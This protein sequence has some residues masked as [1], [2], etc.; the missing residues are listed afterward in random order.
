MAAHDRVAAARSP[1]LLANVM[2][3]LS[4]VAGITLYGVTDR[5]PF[6]QVLSYEVLRHYLGVNAFSKFNFK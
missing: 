4:A 2:L 3:L 5:R 6:H 1:T